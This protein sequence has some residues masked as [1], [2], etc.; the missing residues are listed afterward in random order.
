M[1]HTR[2]INTR[3]NNLHYRALRIIYQDE[4]SSF[5]E[6]LR[7]DGSVTI[8][9]RNLQFLVT[10]LYKVTKGIGPLL[11]A[12][13]FP[14]NPNAN[15]QDESVGSRLKST[16]Y[17]VHNTKKVNSGLET[18]TCLGPKIWDLIPT[19]IRNMESLALFQQKIKDWIPQKC[20]CRLC[21]TYIPQLG[22]L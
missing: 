19:Q 3:I 18:I 5:E 8:H 21:K 15:L 12:E 17:N 10:E 1:F 2:Q 20:P 9:N 4:I 13:I 6:L 14:K 16:F 11:L 22:F 7:K